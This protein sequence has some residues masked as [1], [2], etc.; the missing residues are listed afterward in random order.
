ML[1]SAVRISVLLDN[2][3]RTEYY[4]THT[5]THTLTACFA[6]LQY[7]LYM[8]QTT[9]HLLTHYYYKLY[10]IL[11]GEFDHGIQQ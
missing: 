8:M 4:H 1:V 10:P 7:S 6:I 3:S 5:H 2:A 11:I 9:G